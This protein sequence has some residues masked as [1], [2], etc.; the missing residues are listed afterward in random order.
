MTG[1]QKSL[2]MLNHDKEDRMAKKTKDR[3]I[4]KAYTPAQMAAKLRRLA[5]AIEH[6]KPFQI[7]IGGERV[8]I[9]AG[10]RFS[11]E[12]EREGNQEEVE[13]Q[14]TWEKTQKRR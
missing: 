1:E 11:I 7:M 2:M 5:D 6:E 10:T 8:Y 3:D 9:P 13:F 14:F 4:E 12:H